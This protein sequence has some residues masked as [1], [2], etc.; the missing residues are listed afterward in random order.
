MNVRFPI[1]IALAALLV[2]CQPSADTSTP[3]PGQTSYT[4][5][6]PTV[7]RSETT[8]ASDTSRPRPGA[9]EVTLTLDRTSYSSGADVT[10]RI[11]NSGRDTLGYNPCSNRVVE[12]QDG[13]SWTAVPEPNRMCTMELRL[14]NP[15]QTQTAGTD[16][17]SPLP[18]G[19]YRIAL[20]LGRQTTAGGSVRAVS[21]PF[22]IR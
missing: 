17:P 9:A 16:L 12:R 5:G 10:M 11:Q 14:L 2:A 20:T 7:T 21:G 6:T 15:G 1:P 19:T 4:K 8:M 18:A 3:A 13:S 22:S